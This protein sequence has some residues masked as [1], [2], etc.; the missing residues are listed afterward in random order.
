MAQVSSNK[1]LG[2]N[3]KQARAYNDTDQDSPQLAY[4]MYYYW[5]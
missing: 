5:K 1:T 3:F 2:F 4:N